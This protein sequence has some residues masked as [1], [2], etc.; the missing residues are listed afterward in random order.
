MKRISVPLGNC[1]LAER[2]DVLTCIGIGSCVVV[3]LYDPEMGLAAMAHVMLPGR[4]GKA[5]ADLPARYSERAIDYM[6][7]ELLARGSRRERLRAKIAGGAEMFVFSSSQPADGP[8]KKN[9]EAITARLKREG[10]TIAGMDVGENFG[11]SVEFHTDTGEMIVRAA[12]RPP[13]VI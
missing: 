12:T 13:R 1:V 6:M 8:G 3:T 2:P 11:R 10:I 4:G 9:V 7:R 5:E